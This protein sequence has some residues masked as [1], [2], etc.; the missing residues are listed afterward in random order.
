MALTRSSS[1]SITSHTLRLIL[2]AVFFGA[3][4]GALT[5][6]VALI[7]KVCASFV[8]ASSEAGYHALRSHLYLLPV[9]LLCLL[10]L[11][12]LLSWVYR[13]TPNLRGG[14]IP[15]SIGVLRGRISIRWLR[16]LFGIFFLS[17]SSFFVGVPL[18]NEG[19]A[20]QMGTAIGR[21]T[22][23]CGSRKQ[24]A[25]DRY[26]M[27]GGACSGFSVVTGAPI[28]GI[29]FAVEEAH[30]RISPMILLVASVS[31]MFAHITSELLAPILQ[32]ETCLFP[33]MSLMSLKIQ[34]VWIPVVIAVAVGL[35][36]VLFM[37]VYRLI[38]HFFAKTLKRVPQTLKIA[39]VYGVTVLLGLCSFSFVSTGHDL[40][41]ELFEGG[42]ASIPMLILILAARMLLTCSANSSK[43]TGGIF[44][45]ILAIGAILAALLGRGMTALLGLGE[46]YMSII[47]VLGITACISGMMKT[48]LSAIVFAVEALSGHENIVYVIVVAALSFAITEL[49]RVK[50]VNDSVLEEIMEEL[51]AGKSV[52]VIDTMVTVQEG[53]F[54]V[55]KQVRDIFWPANLFVLSVRHDEKAEV[56]EQ[57]AK[58]IL[59]GDVLHV[60]YSTYDEKETKKELMAIVGEQAYQ[61]KEADVI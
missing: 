22:V 44:V 50:S 52:K 51:N 10:G 19:P 56:D 26:A 17:L 8:I 24:R 36:A 59:A 13:I 34:D 37:W 31:V 20:V 54:A 38:K 1:F 29:L 58:A 3:V 55:G 48:P 35:F 32:V 45:P 7:Y 46:E 49:F 53:A 60:R 41:V 23:A 21:G 43:L 11:A 39:M 15:T 61:E 6:A 57:N 16:N 30:Q 5:A 14:G 27:T 2:P 9:V 47:L 18:G 25:W 42:G 28:S 4:T 12:F 33:K 40:I